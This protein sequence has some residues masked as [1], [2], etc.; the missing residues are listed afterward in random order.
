MLIFQG[1]DNRTLARGMALTA[2]W[3]RDLVFHQKFQRGTA[4]FKLDRENDRF[5]RRHPL[6]GR[7]TILVEPQRTARIGG[8]DDRRLS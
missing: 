7:Q 2:A 6:R 8:S 5:L 4:R 3:L 1:M